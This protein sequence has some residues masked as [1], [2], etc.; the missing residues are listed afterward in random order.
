MKCFRISKNPKLD[1][2]NREDVQVS[3]EVSHNTQKE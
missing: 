1:T 3:N 2:I